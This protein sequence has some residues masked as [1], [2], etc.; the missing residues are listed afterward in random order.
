MTSTPPDPQSQPPVLPDEIRRRLDRPV[1]LVGM[2]G[3]GKSTIGRKL[4]QALTV[5]FHDADEEI[6]HAAQLSISDIFE[7]FGEEYFRDGERRVL[8]RLVQ[9]ERGVIATGGGAFADPETRAL[10]LAKGVAVWLDCPLDV[11]VERTT[12]RDTRPLL[13]DG[14]PHAILAALLAEREPSYRQAQI[15]VESSN[16]PHNETVAAILERLGAWL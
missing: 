16:N 15:R 13:R 2:M 8:S 14:D 9:E 1:V 11:L 3:S 7:R 5:Q 4:A 12:R 10:I 6:E